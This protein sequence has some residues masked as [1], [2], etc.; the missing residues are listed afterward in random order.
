MIIPELPGY[1]TSLGGADYKGL[2]I[3]LF[4][5]TA[6]LS[7]PFSGK[8]A[9]KIGRIPVMIFG[10]IVSFVSAFFY[11]FII[12]VGG[13]LMLRFLHGFSTGFMPT[14]IS[15]YVAD[16]VPA[17]WR[18]EA[19]GII[20]LATSLGM[21][22]GPAI[23][24]FLAAAFSLNFMFYASSFTSLFSMVIL[25]GLKET[26]KNKE[27]LRPRLLKISW[28][29]IFEPKV[30]PPSVV[31]ML[32]VF[33]F[34]IILTIIP[35]FSEHLQIENKGYF[36]SV[37]TLS[38]LAVRLLAGKAS[39]KYGRVIVLKISSVVIAIAMIY[40][41]FANS[42]TTFLFAAIIFGL[43]VGMNSPTVFAWTIDLSNEKHRGR[44]MATMFIALELGLGT[45][46]LFSG[47]FYNNK[48]AMFPYTFW[49]G[50]I[51]AVLSFIYLQFVYKEKGMQKQ[52]HIS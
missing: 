6:G 30:I 35:D 9:D 21:A 46:A 47:F 41:G 16:I 5:L 13:F 39:D 43:G 18:G 1:L 37:F 8:L 34:G 25:A 26:L 28:K 45:G 17:H 49:S 52:T 42:T 33:S 2:I 4:T 11:P 48:A 10:A 24:S 14:G 15:A 20:G 7:R 50:G 12:T 22:M 51:L 31:M 38:S 23:G 29:D 40:L 19:M 3:A 44:A 32:S 36:F 27:P